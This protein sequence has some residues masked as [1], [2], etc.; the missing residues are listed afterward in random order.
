MTDEKKPTNISALEQFQLDIARIPVPQLK[1]EHTIHISHELH[2]RIERL[3]E[4]I[5]GAIKRI[6]EVELPKP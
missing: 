4:M 2:T 1:G 3:H 5:A 6:G